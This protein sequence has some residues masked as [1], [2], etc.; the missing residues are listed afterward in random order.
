MHH[1]IDKLGMDGID[2]LKMPTANK[3]QELKLVSSKDNDERESFISIPYL[4][5]EVLTENDQ[6][7]GYMF[8]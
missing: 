1:E 6:Y 3:N 4:Q 7:K 5:S 2:T 8:K